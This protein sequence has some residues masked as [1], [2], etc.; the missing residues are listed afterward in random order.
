[1]S[2]GALRL[3]VLRKTLHV[4]TPA[5]RPVVLP[6]LRLTCLLRFAG[7][8]PWTDC[9]VDTGS[10]YNVFGERHWRKFEHDIDWV[11]DPP[12]DVTDVG[13][14]AGGT[15]P[16]RF[17]RVP[18]ELAGADLDRIVDL[19]TIVAVMLSDDEHLPTPLVGLWGGV[20]AGR[21][22]VVEPD[23]ASARLEAA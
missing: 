6:M 2:T 14:V 15:Y 11:A 9:W 8:T 10:P 21:R 7:R 23:L 20:L 3:Y 5:G 18:A 12:A 16:Y 13:R 4:V 1:M 22:L 17:G 19:G